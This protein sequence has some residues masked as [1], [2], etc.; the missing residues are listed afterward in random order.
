MSNIQSI[1]NNLQSNYTICGQVYITS[2]AKRHHSYLLHPSFNP[3][4]HHISYRIGLQMMKRENSWNKLFTF[5]KSLRFN[6]P[7][8]RILPTCVGRYPLPFLRKPTSCFKNGNGFE[9]S[10]QISSMRPR[11]FSGATKLSFSHHCPFW[12][13]VSSPTSQVLMSCGDAYKHRTLGNRCS[14]EMAGSKSLAVV[15]CRSRG[16]QESSWPVSYERGIHTA[17]NELAVLD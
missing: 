8:C 5:S 9:L 16:P 10:L 13:S 17:M 3:S 2:S 14:S 11:R 6:R 4:S 12:P 1:D 15:G 7:P